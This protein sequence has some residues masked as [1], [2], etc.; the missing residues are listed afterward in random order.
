MVYASVLITVFVSFHFFL[1]LINFWLSFHFL[2]NFS[3]TWLLVLLIF[4]YCLHFKLIILNLNFCQ[5]YSYGE[6]DS[7]TWV[8]RMEQCSEYGQTPSLNDR[9]LSLRFADLHNADYTSSPWSKSETAG[10]SKHVRNSG[11]PLPL[12]PA[13]RDFCSASGTVWPVLRF[14]PNFLNVLISYSVEL[15]LLY[16]QPKASWAWFTL[17]HPDSQLQEFFSTDCSAP[18]LIKSQHEWVRLVSLSQA[19]H[20]SIDSQHLRNSLKW[21]HQENFIKLQ[22]YLRLLFLSLVSWYLKSWVPR[23]YSGVFKQVYLVCWFHYVS[24]P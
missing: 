22:T 15:C 16:E 2:L 12:Q 20:S 13:D 10:G 23:E 17:L 8:D 7:Y 5:F 9:P 3:K 21:I 4:L 24:L 14:N 1:F 19:T 6:P 18:L 11:F